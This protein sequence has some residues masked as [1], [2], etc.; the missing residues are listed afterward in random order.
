MIVFVRAVLKPVRWVP[1]SGVKIVFTKESISSLYPSVHCMA[2]S[3][4]TPFLSPEKWMG[5]EWMGVLDLFRYC[6]NSETPPS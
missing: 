2:M 6:T 4:I 5:V 3:I 1:P